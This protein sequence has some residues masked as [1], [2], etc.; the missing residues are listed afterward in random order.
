MEAREIGRG[1]LGWG[2]RYRRGDTRTC[3]IKADT[4]SGRG[5]SRQGLGEGRINLNKGDVKNP[6]GSLTLCE[7][8]TR[9][10][11]TDKMVQM[12]R[13]FSTLILEPTGQRERTNPPAYP[14][15]SKACYVTHILCSHTQLIYIS[16]IKI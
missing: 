10:R 3:D 4:G 16:Q 13:A 9:K 15:T 11:R 2:M 12:V 8:I 5:W 7:V 14:L 6:Y 1:H